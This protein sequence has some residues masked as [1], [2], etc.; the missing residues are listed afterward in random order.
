M[1][2]DPRTVVKIGTRLWSDEVALAEQCMDPIPQDDPAYQF[3]N[4]KKFV[5][6]RHYFPANTEPAD[7]PPDA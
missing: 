5:V 3:S 1:A 2:Q 7:N 4:N 6:K